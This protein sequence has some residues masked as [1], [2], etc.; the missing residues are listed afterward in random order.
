MKFY[1]EYT[2]QF[3]DTE[4]DCVAAEQELKAKEEAEIKEA[5]KKASEKKA[6][7]AHLNELKAIADEAHNNYRKALN[8]Y[9]RDYGSF[10]RTYN[11]ADGDNL[12]SLLEGIFNF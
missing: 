9:L 12:M 3:Y 10:S 2:K 6:R 7:E 11:M 5:N 8:S 1:S 4:E